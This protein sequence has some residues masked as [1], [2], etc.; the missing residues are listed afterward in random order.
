MTDPTAEH[1]AKLEKEAKA[2]LSRVRSAAELEAWRV[3]YLGRKGLVPRLLRSVK[4]LPAA[5]R[6]TVGQKG[7]ALRAALERS[8]NERAALQA[9][10]SATKIKDKT[11]PQ[12]E[13]PGHLHPLTLAMR[14]IEAIFS[15]LGFVI[16]EGPLVEEA[17]VNF[18]QLNIPLEHPARAE[19]DT[20]YIGRD[21][22]LRTSTS[23]V[24]IRSVQQLKL[25]PPFK[26]FSPGRVFRAE[27]PDATH[28][29]TFH[30]V[31]GLALGADVTIADFK[32]VI[33]YFY[34]KMFAKDVAIRL[35]PHYFP[36]VEPGFEV[37][38]SCVF[39]SSGCKVCKGTRWIE[40]LGAGMVHPNVIRNMGFDPAAIQGYAFGGG[41]DRLVMLIHGIDDLRL[42]WAGDL[43][44]LR[45]FD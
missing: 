38:I 44:F 10:P 29:H 30:Q 17:R 11:D 41:I 34:S 31:E 18:D 45:Q 26:M 28:S 37:D 32:G 42:L 1:L 22:V 21:K 24:Q 7:N 35:R 36:F 6:R 3:K 23:P 27:K 16:A 39:C 2:A 8:Y 4:D 13:A 19:T 5:E 25:R 14:R 43:R 40:M 33:E 9:T 12:A 15:E 20:Y